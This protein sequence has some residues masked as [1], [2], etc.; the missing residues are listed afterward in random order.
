MSYVYIDQSDKFLKD[1]VSRKEFASLKSI[2][3]T[4]TINRET[5]IF[6]D[7]LF[8]EPYDTKGLHLKTYQNFIRYFISPNTPYNRILLKHSTGSGKTITSL[9][10]AKEFIKYMKLDTVNKKPAGTVYVIGFSQSVFENELMRWPEFGFISADE[11]EKIRQLKAASFSG[12][13]NDVQTLVD[14]RTKIKKRFSNRKKNGFFVF[15]GYTRFANLLYPYP[16]DC[17]KVDEKFVKTFD[18]SLI[19]ADEIHNT[20][21]SKETNKWGKGL[22]YILDNAKNIRALM[23]SA[24]PLSNEPSEV[25]DLINLLNKDNTIKRSHIFAKNGEILD[26]AKKQISKHIIGKVSFVQDLNPDLFPSYVYLGEI[27]PGIKDLK[28]T[29][30]EMKGIYLNTYKQDNRETVNLTEDP[31]IDGCWP[32]P[33]SKS[34]GLYN[35]DSYAKI[36]NGPEKWKQQNKI[37]V[38]KR[39]ITGNFLKYGL[40]D[41]YFPKYNRMMTDIYDIIK[42]GARETTTCVGKSHCGLGNPGKIFIFHKNVCSSGILFINQILLTNGF[43]HPG[44][45]PTENTICVKCSHR[46][47][48][49]KHNGHNFTPARFYV[50]SSLSSKSEINAMLDHYNSISNIS[51]HEVLILLASKMIK[52]AYDIKAIQH[53]MIMRRPDNIPTLIQIIGRGVRN[54]SHLGLPE[55]HKN[56]NIR[57]YVNSFATKKTGGFIFSWGKS[58]QNNQIEISEIK[59]GNTDAT[60]EEATDEEATD[61]EATDEEATDEEATDEEATDE[62]TENNEVKEADE[63]T[64]NNEVKI[65][66][67]ITDDEWTIVNNGR[68]EENLTQ[69]KSDKIIREQEELTKLS[70]EALEKE[71]EAKYEQEELTK[72]SLEA[73]EKEKEAKYEQEELTKLSLEALEKEKQTKREQ[74]IEWNRK[75]KEQEKLTKRAIEALKKEQKQKSTKQLQK[76]QEQIHRIRKLTQEKDLLKR[77]H[78]RKGIANTAYLEEL[79]SFD[80]ILKQRELLRKLITLKLKGLKLPFDNRGE[81]LTIYIDIDGVKVPITLLPK[82]KKKRRKKK[83]IKK[84]KIKKKKIK[85]KKIKKKKIKKSKKKGVK[86]AIGGKVKN[87]LTHEEQKYKYKMHKY[88][89]IEELE[90]IFHEYSIDA[91]INYEIIMKSSSNMIPYRPVVEVPKTLLTTTFEAY[92]AEDEMKRIETIINRL[93]IQVSPMW[94]VNTLWEAVKNPPFKINEN[95]KLYNRKIYDA[96]LNNILWKNIKNDICG[97]NHG[98]IMNNKLLIRFPVING[99][100]VTDYNNIFTNFDY[101]SESIKLTINIRKYMSVRKRD[102]GAIKNIWDSLPIIP[103]IEDLNKFSCTVYIKNQELVVKYA[104]Q[105]LLYLQ[106]NKNVK[107][108]SNPKFCKSKHIVEYYCTMD[109]LLNAKE[110]NLYS[111]TENYIEINLKTIVGYI[112]ADGSYI[113]SYK[114]NTDSKKH[115]GDFIWKEMEESKT[116]NQ[117]FVENNIIVGYMEGSENNIFMKFKLRRPRHELKEFQDRRFEHRGAI[118]ETYSKKDLI[119]MAKKLKASHTNINVQTLCENIRSKLLQLEFDERKKGSNLKYFYHLWEM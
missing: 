22:Q 13:K 85:K 17:K 98:I 83:K 69:I 110:V 71:K 99:K 4:E 100:L 36:K 89:K 72:L 107:P 114:G 78:Y 35:I 76:E 104:I 9:S 44:M 102:I 90:K 23:M 111:E 118:C 108:E 46:K 40:L 67:E 87:P 101:K 27:I 21:N 54:N 53:I 19:I 79:I 58:E 18:N 63:E 84:K 37:I 10:V 16:D 96:A 20:Y 103:S 77:D 74:E 30:C 105:N 70:L 2:E 1:I 50:V 55:N 28:F 31:I 25:V 49:G 68:V 6:E 11:L 14:F 52:E 51:G 24:T 116:K 62:E 5:A 112:S 12:T 47:G 94:T 56:V 38:K 115:E 64:E 8:L 34:V 93:F 117:K 61:E 95:S 109:I 66:K 91:P 57:L 82:M 65:N 73:L 80:K 75:L 48:K 33:N 97:N 60:D 45:F 86:Q 7:K 39:I 41:N 81:T 26:G 32:N 59:E 106:Y 15:M 42:N 92:Y 119:E 43:I 3:N 113:V 29:R 88:E